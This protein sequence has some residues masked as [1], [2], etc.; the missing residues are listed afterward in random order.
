MPDNRRPRQISRST[1]VEAIGQP[2]MLPSNTAGHCPIP[3]LERV[4][5]ANVAEQMGLHRDLPVRRGRCGARPQRRPA[6]PPPSLT[7]PAGQ[8]AHGWRCGCWS[9]SLTTAASLSD[10]VGFA[11]TSPAS[12][13]QSDHRSRET[14]TCASTPCLP[15]MSRDS[16]NAGTEPTRALNQPSPS[17]RRRRPSSTRH[18]DTG[19]NTPLAV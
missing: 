1:R 7:R 18:V 19:R 8:S 14:R 2:A 13:R 3:L 6:Q 16:V 15:Y 12:K 9:T 11:T 5:T 17:H 10:P 4:Q